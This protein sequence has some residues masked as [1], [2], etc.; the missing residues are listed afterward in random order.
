MVPRLFFRRDGWDG[1]SDC[2]GHRSRPGSAHVRAWFTRGA[3]NADQSQPDLPSPWPRGTMPGMT[4]I[5]PGVRTRWSERALAVAT[6]LLFAICLVAAVIGRKWPSPIL[7]LPLILAW[8]IAWRSHRAPP[9]AR[10]HARESIN[11]QVSLQIVVLAMCAAS[12]VSLAVPVW[13]PFFVV[14]VVA[15]LAS[16]VQSCLAAKHAAAGVEDRLPL[17]F[18]FL[19]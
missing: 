19:G 18:G 13:V 6:H 5:E 15:L 17:G 9:F 16:F 4:A 3:S 11:L 1:H 8:W 12:R 2:T 14:F 7:V 10:A